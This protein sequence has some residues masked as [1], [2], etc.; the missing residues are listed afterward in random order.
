[1]DEAYNTTTFIYMNAL[2]FNYY[3][4][5]NTANKAYKRPNRRNSE[6]C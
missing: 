2:L 5:G 4:N 3:G 6:A 1:M